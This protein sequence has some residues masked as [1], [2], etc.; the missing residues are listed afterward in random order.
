[1]SVDRKRLFALWRRVTSLSWPVMV[2]QV[3][4][5]LMRTIDIFVTALFSPL[6]VAAIGLA[7]LYAR[8]PLR[9]GLGL[10]AGAI[11]LSSQDT[12]SDA[13]A[14]RDEAVTQAL[15]IG[16]LTGI[17]FAVFGVTLGEEAIAI[18]GIWAEQDQMADVA[19]LGGT[20]LAIVFLTAPAR[21]VALIGAR[22]LQGTGDTR[23]PMYVN[24]TSNGLNIV[25]S[26]VLGLGLFGA[27]RLEIVGV[28]IATAFGNI[29]TA[30]AFVLA[31]ATDWTPADFTYP[32]RLVIAKQLFVVSAPKVAEGMVATAVEFPFNAL[33][34][35]FGAEVNA[36][37]QIGR[38]VYQQVTSP[39]GR[40]LNTG[41][42][43]VVGQ[44]LGEGNPA[45]ARYN[46]WATAAL[47]LVSVGTIG[48]LLAVF[49]EPLAGLFTDDPETLPTAVGFTVSYGLAAPA[50]VLYITLSGSLQG[51]SDTTTPF[52]ARTV[53][54]LA[55]YLGFSYLTSVVLGWGVVGIYAGIV[56]Y[57]V[58][59]L[60]I[61]IAGFQ[62]GDWARRATDMMEDRGSL[63]DG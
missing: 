16:F 33:L 6:A 61:V 42:S 45:E 1:M 53:G 63:A 12:G 9:I 59:A 2:E 46:G 23:T 27:P 54:L 57:Y 52:I 7:D 41:A 34:L 51:G 37:Y 35:S 11:A 4:R 26:L 18:L 28:G 14:N 38:R 49:A 58:S 17:P 5:T 60:V 36:G 25:F 50:T 48:L 40:G 21:H 10:G 39:L 3:S 56:L 13:T 15:L 8:F 22:A 24:L 19:D 44:A 29:F 62:Y 31:I 43:I 32:R 30:S 55:F 47:G 20:Y